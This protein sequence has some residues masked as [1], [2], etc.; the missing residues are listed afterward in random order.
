MIFCKA[1]F[2]SHALRSNTAFMIT[3]IELRIEIEKK[4]KVFLSFVFTGQHRNIWC[5]FNNTA[6]D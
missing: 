6:C 2:L 5:L 3:F 1:E 4:K